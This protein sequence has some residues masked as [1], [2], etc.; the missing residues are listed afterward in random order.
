MAMATSQVLYDAIPKIEADLA[1]PAMA[2]SSLRKEISALLAHMKEV[3]RK[4]DAE[5]T[6]LD[7]GDEE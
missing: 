3:Q 2:S 5:R 1:L 6:E 7:E 4:L